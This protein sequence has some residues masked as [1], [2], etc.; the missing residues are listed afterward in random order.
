MTLAD[1]SHAEES[2]AD[3]DTL[4]AIASCLGYPHPDSATDARRAAAGWGDAY[5]QVA[6][7]FIAL[8]E[9]LEETDPLAVED[10]YTNLFDLKPAC[11]LDLGHHV[12]GEAYQRGALL[13]GL[14]A[15][16][17]EHKVDMRNELPDYLPTVLRL[18]GRLED[19]PEREMFLSRVLGVGVGRMKKALVKIDTPWARAVSSLADVYIAPAE[20]LDETLHQRIR[21]QVLNNA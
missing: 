16:H 11:T 19:T 8:A 18:V 20:E 2:F 12:F 15:E 7:H 10:A 17:R 14:V 6:E 4:D 9:W 3:A 5:P 1:V 21:L 13:A